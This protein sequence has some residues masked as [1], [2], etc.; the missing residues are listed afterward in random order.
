MRD[1]TV[2]TVRFSQTAMLM[3]VLAFGTYASAEAAPWWNPFA[4]DTPSTN[5]NYAPGKMVIDGKPVRGSSVQEPKSVGA[6][7]VDKVGQGTKKM[8]ASTKDALSFKK[9]PSVPGA[10]GQPSWSRQVPA[11][12]KP[13][14]QKPGMFSSLFKPKQPEAPR[15]VEEFLQQPRP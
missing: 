13:A 4:R 7:A 9:K 12:R 3:L 15:T 2:N 6:S 1:I 11:Q 8:F 5:P 14:K 10:N